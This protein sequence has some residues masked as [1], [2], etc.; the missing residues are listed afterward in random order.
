MTLLEIITLCFEK[1]QSLF[2]RSTYF[3]S[4]HLFFIFILWLVI[5]YLHVS[6]IC[7]IVAQNFAI[8]HQNC[9]TFYVLSCMIKMMVKLF[10]FWWI[11]E[12]LVT[13][14]VISVKQYLHQ[15]HLLSPHLTSKLTGRLRCEKM[16][17]DFLSGELLLYSCGIIYKN[18][19][20]KIT[21]SC[22]L[23]IQPQVG[24]LLFQKPTAKFISDYTC[25]RLM[26]AKYFLVW[27]KMV[28]LSTKPRPNVWKIVM[29]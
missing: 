2:Y 27:E 4:S 29:Q 5:K 18:N 8:F 1:K 9:F 22:C 25:M 20:D 19:S 17:S 23:Q 12:T 21:W 13:S 15:M 6:S 24:G 28:A 11:F 10:R 3:C 14:Q 16:Y 26:Y 7:F